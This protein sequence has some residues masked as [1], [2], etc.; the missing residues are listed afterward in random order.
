[1]SMPLDVVGDV[2]LVLQI[3]I[4]F[5]LIIGLHFFRGSITKK[6]WM[7]HGYSTIAAL[8]LHTVLIFAVM[9]PTLASGIDETASLNFV[10]SFTVWSHAVLGTAAEVAGALLVAAWIISGPSKLKCYRWRKWML[11]TFIIWVI[12]IVNGA[13]VHIYGL[14]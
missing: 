4:L 6:N 8:V 14:I 11:P 13:F 2:S 7:W 3:V 5:L 9:V 10:S 12:A 1:M